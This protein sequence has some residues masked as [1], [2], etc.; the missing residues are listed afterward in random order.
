M[1]CN[2]IYC[3][4]ATTTGTGVVLIPNR[5]IRNLDNTRTYGLV[6]CCGASAS[7]NLP[8]FIQTEI[9]NIPVLCKFGNEL[10][11]NQ[12]SRRVRYPLG[13]GNQNPN[14]ENGQF[15]ITSCCNISPRSTSTSKITQ[16]DSSKN[17][18]KSTK[19]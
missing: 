18:A 9:G 16:D 17:S 1:N 2:T 8:V 5:T 7:A 11:A 13:Y 3:S 6:I 14:Y 19:A 15:V 4:N 10:Y 12:L